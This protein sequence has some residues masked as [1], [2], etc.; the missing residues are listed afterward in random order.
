MDA[1]FSILLNELK[2]WNEKVNLTAITEDKD[3]LKKHFEDSLS[4]LK[5]LPENTESI[6]D[7]GSGAGF[8]GLPIGIS[9]PDIKITLLE[10]VGKKVAWL[11][12]IIKKLNLKNIKVLNGRAEDF[13]QNPDFREKFDVAVSRGVAEL[14]VLAEYC[15]PFVKV[16]GLMIAQK[17]INSVEIDKAKNS[18]SVLG[19]AIEAIIPIHIDGLEDRQLIVIKKISETPKNYP[20]RA[21]MPA[22]KMIL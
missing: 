4:V 9:R 8:P 2:A 18:L 7:V 11:E 10:S 14:R 3:I 17:N 21:G 19:G 15:L 5:A 16:G 1:K 22:K 6:I 13:G 12:H 20:R